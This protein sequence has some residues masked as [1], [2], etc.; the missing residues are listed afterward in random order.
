MQRHEPLHSGKAS[1]SSRLPRRE[2]AT[3][4]S[5][6]RVHIKKCRF[7]EKN[8]SLSSQPNDLLD[9]CIRK[10]TIDDINDFAAGSDFHDLLL[11]EAKGKDGRLFGL[12][13]TPCDVDKSI[14]VRATEDRLL[15]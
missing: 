11:E 1:K 12:P 6:L 3:H 10:S 2:M 14:V 13:I 4:R 15:K 9:I 7:D 5:Q 8:V